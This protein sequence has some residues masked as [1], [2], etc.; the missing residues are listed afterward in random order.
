[1]RALGFVLGLVACSSPPPVA[2]VRS[3]PPLDAPSGKD[4]TWSADPDHDGILGACDQCPTE[5]ESIND[6]NNGDGCP[7]TLEEVQ[8]VASD[9]RVVYSGPLYVT[10]GGATI[11]GPWQ[12]PEDV[13][14]LACIGV[15]KDEFTARERADRLCVSVEQALKATGAKTTTVRYWRVHRQDEQFVLQVMRASG[16]DI[17]KWTNAALE[18]AVPRPIVGKP[19]VDGCEWQGFYTN[20]LDELR[21]CASDGCKGILSSHY[22]AIWPDAPTKRTLPPGKPKPPKHQ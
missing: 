19:A 2:P 15:A 11:S 16:V 10:G 14:V 12:I 1:M 13:D 4:D 21:L 17:W 6:E 3:A 5:P 9:P 18:R 20:S 22:M 7:E 8:R